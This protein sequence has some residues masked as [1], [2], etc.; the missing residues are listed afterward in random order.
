V[1][2]GWVGG[3]G[4]MTLVLLLCVVFAFCIQLLLPMWA[5]VQ[6][7]TSHAMLV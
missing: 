1:W 3:G 6:Y 2:D 4:C 7:S 5:E